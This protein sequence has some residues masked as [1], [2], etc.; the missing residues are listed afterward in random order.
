MTRPKGVPNHS[1]ARVKAIL[2]E[3]F[4]KRGGIPAMLA[5]SNKNP[6]EF[7][8]LWIRCLPAEAKLDIAVNHVVHRNFTGRT[9]IESTPMA[10]ESPEGATDELVKAVVALTIPKAAERD[11]DGFSD[12]DEDLTNDTED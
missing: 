6:T 9:V 11:T 3:V 5:W 8:K 7:Y 2:A 4:D 1:T 12:L 10:L